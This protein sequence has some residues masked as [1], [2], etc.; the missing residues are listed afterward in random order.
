[1]ADVFSPKRR[2]AIMAR[3]RASGNVETELRLISWLREF[4]IQGWRRGSRLFG[5]PDL[6]FSKERLVVFVDGCFWHGCP[7]CYKEPK[8][9]HEFWRKKVTSNRARAKLVNRT[10]R[11]LGWRV[12]RVWQ[13]DLKV[14]RK[15]LIIR[16]IRNLLE[17]EQ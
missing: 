13:H 16:R 12:T 3:I 2:S 5:R 6:V 14:R 9:N 11:A 4:Q 8:S 17:A 15:N 10:L 1:M 7:K